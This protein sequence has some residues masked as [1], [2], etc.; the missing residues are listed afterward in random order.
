MLAVGDSV[1]DWGWLLTGFE[2][3]RGL[4]EVGLFAF[5][6]MGG[7][8]EGFAFDPAQPISFLNIIEIY[9]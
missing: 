4:D 2:L 9:R 7:L 3:G 8:G 1:D 6:L 5:E